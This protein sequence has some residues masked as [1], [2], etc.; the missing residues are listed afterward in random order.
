M[1]KWVCYWKCWLV[2]HFPQ[3]F[4]WS[5]SLLNGYNWV[6]NGIMVLLIIIPMKNGQLS[7]GIYP[8]F[9]D[10]P[11]SFESWWE[12]GTSGHI[13]AHLGTFNRL[14]I[15]CLPCQFNRTAAFLRK[16]LWPFPLDS[17]QAYR[18]KAFTTSRCLWDLIL[19]L[20]GGYAYL[21]QL[22][23]SLCI[24]PIWTMINS[25]K[26]FNLSARYLSGKGDV[27][28]MTV[29]S[30]VEVMCS[31]SIDW[32]C[33]YDLVWLHSVDWVWKT[34]FLLDRQGLVNVPFWGYWTSPYSSHYRP[35]T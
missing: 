4:S 24:G 23:G 32:A 12:L 9:S 28:A 6:Y 33:L 19:R 13:W 11:K 30:L 25:L 21:R 22:L 15:A 31:T 35:Y 2:P 26:C 27:E 7:L 20:G 18:R 29:L 8:T 10:N 5:L 14:S 1:L 16:F 34:I 3:W 17:K